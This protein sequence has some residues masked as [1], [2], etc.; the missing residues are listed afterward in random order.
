MGMKLFT[1]DRFVQW[2]GFST[3][4]IVIFLFQAASRTLSASK[5]QLLTSEPSISQQF[6]R[7]LCALF[8][9]KAFQYHRVAWRKLC[10]WTNTIERT[11]VQN[12]NSWTFTASI[13]TS[14]HRYSLVEYFVILKCPVFVFR[15]EKTKLETRAKWSFVVINLLANFTINECIFPLPRV[16]SHIKTNGLLQFTWTFLSYFFLIY[17]VASR[18]V[19]VFL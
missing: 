4:S 1:F 12:R 19:P 9:L 16:T 8:V 10:M 7:K 14:V 2:C 3:N 18:P 11:S 13:T 5:D 17:T 6:C 15:R